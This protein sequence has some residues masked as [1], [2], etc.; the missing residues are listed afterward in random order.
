MLRVIISLGVLFSLAWGGMTARAEVVLLVSVGTTVRQ[1]GLDGSNQGV[2]ATLSGQARGIATYAGKIYVANNGDGKVY[3]Y[4]Q[5]GQLLNSYATGFSLTGINLRGLAV[6]SAGNFY[7]GNSG[8]GQIRK[9]D[10]SWTSPGNFANANVRGVALN[11][12]DRLVAGTAGA[13]VL[14]WAS[15]SPPS[16]S[17]TYVT[18]TGTSSPVTQGVNFDS[19]GNLYV[20]DSANDLIRKYDTA[21]TLDRTFRNTGDLNGVADVVIDSDGNVYGNS[22]T[23][24]S[25]TKFNSSGV[26]QWTRSTF[27]TNDTTYMTLASVPEPSTLLLGGIAAVCGGG[28]VWWKRRKRPAAQ[29]APTEAESEVGAD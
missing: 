15:T 14:T 22:F 5:G 20:A 28:G 9:F 1:Y 6:D 16:T 7:L 13:S 10:S 27:S 25:V 3:E 2:F 12:S 4:N 19:A 11:S 17:S 23:D 21:G 18:L 26:F 8:T 24:G 29:P